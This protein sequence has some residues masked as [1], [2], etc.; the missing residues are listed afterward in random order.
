TLTVFD[1]NGCTTSNNCV[2][3]LPC[4]AMYDSP[5]GCPVTYWKATQNFS[6]WH[7]PY[8]PAAGHNG[9]TA[10][11]FCDVLHV[12]NVTAD[13][14]APFDKKSLLQVLKQSGRG[15]E[16]LG[17]QVVAAMLNADSLGSAFSPK[18]PNSQAVIHKFN[19]VLKKNNNNPTTSQLE[20]LRIE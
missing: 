11:R 15:Y 8:C 12:P 3:N 16:A 7:A 17:R 13:A 20:S 18:Y 10:T 4:Q 2:L 5:Q 19:Q 9:S 14:H 1:H 6:D